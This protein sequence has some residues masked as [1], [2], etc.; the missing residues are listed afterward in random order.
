MNEGYI[1]GLKAAAS[2]ISKMINESGSCLVQVSGGVY[3]KNGVELSG[4]TFGYFELDDKSKAK[5]I[6]ED[7]RYFEGWIKD[8]KDLAEGHCGPTYAYGIIDFYDTDTDKR[9]ARRRVELR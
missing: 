6:I 9:L 5:E 3:D 8:L 7:D 1:N 4:D 2:L